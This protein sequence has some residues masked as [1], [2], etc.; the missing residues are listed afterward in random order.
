MS[1]IL[2]TSSAHKAEEIAHVLERPL[3]RHALDL[4]EVQAID[5]QQVIE[6]KVKAAYATVQQPVLVEDTGLLIHSWQGLPGALI[7]WFLETV[8]NDG[9]C[10]ML[11][12][13][14]DRSATAITCIGYF[15][16]THYQTFLG[17]TTGQIAAQPRGTSGFGWDPIFVPD[18]YHKTFAELKETEIV[19]VSMRRKATLA[20]KQFLDMQ[21]ELRHTL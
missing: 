8:G 14:A 2:A 4:P 9:I 6:A 15:D 3:T 21:E 20:L 5:V 11:A 16:G 13:F 1:L 19:A 10:T 12:Q 18:G 17:E 7:R